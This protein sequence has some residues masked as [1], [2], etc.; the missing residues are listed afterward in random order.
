MSKVVINKDKVRE[1]VTRGVEA[2]Y[3]SPALLT[4]KLMSGERIRLYCGFDPTGSALQIGNTIALRKLAQFQELGHEVIFLVGDFTGMIGDPTDKKAARRQLSEQEVKSNAVF[5]KKQAA[6]YINFSGPNPAQILFNSTWNKKLK[7]SDLIDLSARF[8][9][10]QM[11]QRDM[12]QARLKDEKPIYLHEFLYPL[13]QA[14]DSLVMDVDL[15][16][17]GNDQTFNMMC[18]RD[19]LKSVNGKE[20]FVLTMKLLTDASGRKM[21]KS[22]GNAVFLDNSAADMYGKIMS[23]PDE[24]I[25]SAFELCTAVSVKEIERIALSLKKGGNPRDLKARLAREITAINH[26]SGAADLA[27]QQFIN[28]FRKKEEPADIAVWQ[29]KRDKYNI[30]DLL[31]ET[32]LVGSKTEGR[33]LIEQGAIKVRAGGGF[34]E[35]KDAK[36][37]LGLKMETVVSRGKRQFVRIIR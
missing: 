35:V 27:E 2:V 4:K 10:Q 31:V 16:V 20:K 8:T 1:V 30:V 29:A 18:G 25:L 28:T 7:F 9:V 33:R 23:W 12:F 17:G 13:V 3:P 34:I 14:Y 6:A 37:E 21:G 15:E 5:F 26:G 36:L 22:E 32:G 24:V 11:I 19:L